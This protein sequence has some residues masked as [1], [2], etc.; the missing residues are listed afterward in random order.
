MGYGEGLPLNANRS[1]AQ[2]QINRRVEI[3]TQIQWYGRLPAAHISRSLKR[4]T[5]TGRV[6]GVSR[7]EE[8]ISSVREPLY[9]FV[10][11]RSGGFLRIHILTI[12][13]PFITL[14][15]GVWYPDNLH[16]NAPNSLCLILVM[17]PAP[18][19]CIGGY[20][21]CRLTYAAGHKSSVPRAI[22]IT[23][24]DVLCRGG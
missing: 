16:A 22:G 3:L 10:M 8:C 4:L 5:A 13:K 6:V 12:V 14:I 17:R 7:R 2:K 19:S 11:H 20:Y 24:W 1:R 23:D 18:V 21:G 15:R 9:T